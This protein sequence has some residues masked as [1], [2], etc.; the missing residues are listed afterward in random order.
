VDDVVTVLVDA[1]N[2]TAARLRL[3]VESLDDVDPGRVRMVIAGRGA[4]LRAVAWP[5]DAQVIDAAGW[6]R[7]DMALV[8]A[9]ERLG[10]LHGPLVLASGDGDFALLAARHAG[11]VLV[12]S[13]SPSSRL[14]EKAV[15]VDPAL[16]GT[17][18]VR[19]W[20]RAVLDADGE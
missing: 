3:L 11:P 13:G 4:A 17:D 8:E 2:L 19:R 18:P 7:A 10:D 15:V 5:H 20:L 1:D 6:Q 9:Y 16:A 14:R 12:V